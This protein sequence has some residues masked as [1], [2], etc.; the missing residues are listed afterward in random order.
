M[1]K[2]I[3]AL[4]RKYDVLEPKLQQLLQQEEEISKKVEKLEEESGIDIDE[5]R[6]INDSLAVGEA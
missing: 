6:R 2:P 3:P 5:V 4:C 1:G